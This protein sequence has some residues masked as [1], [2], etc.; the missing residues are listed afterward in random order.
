[1]ISIKNIRR[2]G[3]SLVNGEVGTIFRIMCSDDKKVFSLIVG[4]PSGY[5][6]VPKRSGGLVRKR[7][8]GF[9]KTLFVRCSDGQQSFAY[10]ERKQF[11][12]LPFYGVTVQKI[13]GTNLES[14]TVNFVESHAACGPGLEQVAMSRCR[15]LQDSYVTDRTPWSQIRSNWEAEKVLELY[16]EGSKESCQS[17]YVQ[18]LQS[19]SQLVP[20]SRKEEVRVYLMERIEPINL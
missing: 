16:R 20:E 5:V 19:V 11:P 15:K 17:F 14:V 1:M 7:D 13:Q 18:I 12:L 2:L 9:G 4:I 6:R 8:T 3:K 10:L